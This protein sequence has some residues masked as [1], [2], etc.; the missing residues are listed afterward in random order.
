MFYINSFVLCM[1]LKDLWGLVNIED[2]FCEG[3]CNVF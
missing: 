1:I 2:G 3:I